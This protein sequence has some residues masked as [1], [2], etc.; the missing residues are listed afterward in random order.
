MSMSESCRKRIAVLLG[1][2][3]EY[4]HDQFLLGF[5][6]EAMSRDYDVCMFAMYIKYQQS[7]A[8]C[9]GETSIF[10]LPSYDKFDA[11]VVMADTIQTEGEISKIEEELR[12]NYKGPVLFID[13]DSQYFPAIHIDNVTPERTVI[14]HLIEK[15]GFRDIAFLTGK[16]W[17]PHSKIRLQAYKDSL[18]AHGIDVDEDRIFFGDFWY[19]SG[20]SLVDNLLSE[21][22]KLPQAIA[23]ANDYMALGVAKR[24]TERGFKIPDDIAVVGCDGNDE[25]R[26]APIPITSASLSAYN[27]GQN[28]AL[29]TH[30]YI[31]GEEAGHIE[32]RNDLF[33]GESCG[34]A[35]ESARPVYYRREGWDTDMSSSS[36][37]SPVNHMD[38]DLLGQTSFTGLISTIFVSLQH[39]SGFESFNLCLNPALGEAGPAFEQNIKHVI[40]CGSERGR[41]DR[42]LTASYFD[43]S[44]MLPELYEKREKPAAFLFMPLYYEESVFG[45]AVLSYGDRMKVITPEYRA[46]LRSVSRGIEC[47][48]RADALIGS[49]QIAKKGIT[50]DQLTG[51][52]N[53]LGFLEQTETLMNLMKNNGGYM[54]ALA[55]DIKDLSRINDTYGRKAGDNAIITTASALEKVFSSRNC[56]C[57]RVGNDEMVALRITSS[58]DDMEMLAEKDTLM[59]MISE[60]TGASN[61]P[62][63]IELYYGVQSGSPSDSEE[64]ERL[65][66]VAISKKNADKANAM[67]LR[68]KKELTE[69]ELREARTVSRIL[70]DN[71]IYYHFQPIVD[72]NTCRIYGY[73]ALMRADVTPYLS[74]LTILRYAEYYD[75]LYDVE[76]ATFHN[77]LAIMK[78]NEAKFRDGK[79]IFINSIPGCLLRE[80]DLKGVEEYVSAHPDSIIV[81]LT[82]HSE[83]SDET[84]HHMKQTYD[85]I[86][87]KTA[88]DDYGTGY[89]NVSNLLRYK[90][91]YV[92]IDRALVSMIE[93]SPQKRHFVKEIIEFSHENGILAL[94]EGVETEQELKT[95]IMLGVDLI[96]GYYTARPEKDMVQS[97]RQAV[98]DTIRTYAAQRYQSESL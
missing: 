49:S 79:K 70:D 89:S 48:K 76:K 58:S 19:T 96:Q 21:E 39:I 93:E 64:L 31:T 30:S 90:P 51:L 38:E 80:D 73:E 75:R 10:R 59:E 87:I 5:L 83:A 66:N 1:Q 86:G 8:R 82:E 44:E 41:N 92:K 63:T 62:Y 6:K 33:I 56:L 55:I 98:A 16:S 88:V 18:T 12:Q 57:M 72:V 61:E 17:H 7:P 67:K 54:G 85:R 13:K 14:D 35:C 29:L 28:A 43:R 3:E 27:L 4:T 94:A 34:C 25:G 77:V 74:P 65:I 37:F 69:E 15:H 68:E 11:V 26:H 36:M 22:G 53:Y 9:I 71:K 45:Y 32:S 42:I 24:L 84:L 23:C 46:W 91:N 20:A 60:C 40:R 47:Y 78:K 50:T 81:E 97:I 52:V 2:P 95:V